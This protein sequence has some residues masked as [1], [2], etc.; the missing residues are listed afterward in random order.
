[1]SIVRIL[2]VPHNEDNIG[3]RLAALREVGGRPQ[4]LR[5]RPGVRLPGPRH[6]D[7]GL[8]RGRVVR[9]GQHGG[10]G[11]PAAR[12]RPADTEPGLAARRYILKLQTKVRKDFTITKKAPIRAFSWLKAATTTFTFKNL[13]RHY[14][15]QALTPW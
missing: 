3:P 8:P 6:R 12:L 14:T 5:V 11:Q 13:L 10:R 7:L 9:G 4:L 2:L 1:M 15:K